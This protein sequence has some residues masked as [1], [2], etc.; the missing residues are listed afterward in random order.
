MQNQFSPNFD[1]RPF[2]TDPIV[3]RAFEDPNSLRMHESLWVAKP[4]GK[5]HCSRSEVLK[6]AEKWD[7]VGALRIFP[8]DEIGHSEAVGIFAVGKDQDHDRLILNPVVING[9]MKHYSNYTKTLAPGSLMCLVQLQKDEVV[10]ISADDLSEMYYTFR[11]PDCRARQHDAMH[12][13]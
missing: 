13:E 6:L 1:P 12:F 4:A 3:K 10:R 8:G 5:I 2:L 7:A 9:R 11:V